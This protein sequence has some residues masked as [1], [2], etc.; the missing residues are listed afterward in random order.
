MRL[1]HVYDQEILLMKRRLGHFVAHS[2][3]RSS[4]VCANC[5]L[6]G[7]RRSLRQSPAAFSA[8]CLAGSCRAGA[9]RQR[10]GAPDGCGLHRCPTVSHGDASPG[11]FT[12]R[13]A[14]ARRGGTGQAAGSCKLTRLPPRGM[15]PLSHMRPSPAR[16][17]AGVRSPWTSWCRARS[18]PRTPDARIPS[19]SS[20]PACGLARRGTSGSAQR[21]SGRC[22]C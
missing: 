22:A 11:D 5:G 17:G 20:R 14:P 21:S 2:T 3:H 16:R 9:R 8:P 13:P 12:P 15:A 19:R 18:A 6:F 1:N 4:S 10:L 7:S